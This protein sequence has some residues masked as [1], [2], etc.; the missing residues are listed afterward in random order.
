MVR[1]TSMNVDIVKEVEN[2]I[3]EWNLKISKVITESQQLR[4][5]SD[6]VGPILELE[7]WRRQL[8]KFMSIIEHIRRPE[9]KM[10]IQLMFQAR[11]KII[12]VIIR[13]SKTPKKQLFLAEMEGV[14]QSSNR[15]LQRSLR[16][17]QVFVCSG[18]ILRT[19]LSKWSNEDSRDSPQSSL[20][21][22]D[23]LHHLPLLQHHRK[24]NSPS[25]K[26]HQSN[27]DLLQKL[28]W[29][30]SNQV[31]LAPE[32][33]R[34][35]QENWGKPLLKGPTCNPSIKRTGDFRFL[36][37]DVLKDIEELWGCRIFVC[38]NVWTFIWSTTSASRQRR[39]KWTKQMIHLLM[40]LKC[41]SSG[42]LKPSKDA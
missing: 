20:C 10:Y 31:D 4:R 39:G 21:H 42:S 25:C 22:Q 2:I 7:Y 17:R 30:E 33:G 18:K 9:T 40:S 14:G 15:R 37:N 38:R 6:R 27:S 36:R 3:K 5:E 29:W 8:A 41:M 23:G 16:Y 35:H 28:S 26:G 12:K 32:E 24:G 11:S 34:C 13:V 19:T 1:E